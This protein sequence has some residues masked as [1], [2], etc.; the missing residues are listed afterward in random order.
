MRSRWVVALVVAAGCGEDA[1]SVRI[2]A[3]DSDTFALVDVPRGSLDDLDAVRGD[4]I[5]FTISADVESS[6][7]AT[8][9]R[10]GGLD[11]A[12]YVTEALVPRTSWGTGGG[13]AFAEDFDTLALFTAHVQ[14][15]E[16]LL[17]F[18]A[19]GVRDEA[20][21]HLDV[22]YAVEGFG[23]ANAAYYNVADAL[24][25]LRPSH[26]EALPLVMNYGVL[27]HEL[28]HRVQYW[29]LWDGAYFET[30]G[31]GGF[32]EDDVVAYYHLLGLGEGLS[33]Y[34][35]AVV[36]GD[37]GFLHRSFE[38]DFVGDRDVANPKV[39]DPAWLTAD[40]YLGEGNVVDPHVEGA[41]VAAALWEVGEALGHETVSTAVIDA[42]RNLAPAVRELDYAL[43]DYEVEVVR[44]LGSDA[45]PPF[46]AAFE[47]V[48]DRFDSVC[49]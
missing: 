6:L 14:V 36:S 26:L 12:E 27:A 19:L 47:P 9:P 7:G 29:E 35:G 22:H 20:V 38:G 44:L 18:A 32:T 42:Q 28:G 25:L 40:A 11:A 39:L 33:D 24:L 3:A 21:G 41:V 31:S 48:A 45:C 46:L 16:I 5:T 1:T 15:E 10:D 37:S 23:I 8:I 13:T 2:V 30:L 49:P 34:H 17:A 43:G 4:L